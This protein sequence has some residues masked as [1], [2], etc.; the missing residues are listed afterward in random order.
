MLFEGLIN[1][2]LWKRFTKYPKFYQKIVKNKAKSLCL[3]LNYYCIIIKKDTY[4]IIFWPKLQFTIKISSLK[5]IEI[6]ITTLIIGKLSKKR[7]FL[8]PWGYYGVLELTFSH[9]RCGF[10]MVDHP[11]SDCSILKAV[12][13]FLV[14]RNAQ[15]RE[16]FGVLNHLLF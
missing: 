4:P 10:K 13:Q 2:E 5:L 8:S 16:F 15:P 9:L 3:F 7:N 6:G 11:Q 14:Y 12:F 1:Q